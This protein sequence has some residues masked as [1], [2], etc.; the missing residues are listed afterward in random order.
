[1]SYGLVGLYALFFMFVGINGHASPLFTNIEQ[2]AKG[3]APWLL[4]IIIL[5]ALYNVDS[6][7]PAVGPFMG[8]AVLTFVLRNYG[9]LV[10]QTNDITGL[11]LPGATS[12]GA[13]AA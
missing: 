11:S 3:F 7:R 13:K 4:A 12:T 9:T 8:L 10:A 1:M 2:D 6:L 5:R